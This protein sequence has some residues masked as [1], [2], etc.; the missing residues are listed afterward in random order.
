[1]I[2]HFLVHSSNTLPSTS[3]YLEGPGPCCR[4]RSESYSTPEATAHHGLL[5][6]YPMLRVFLI[7][8]D[9]TVALHR[10]D[11]ALGQQG[12]SKGTQLQGGCEITAVQ[13]SCLCTPIHMRQQLNPTAHSLAESHRTTQHLWH[14]SDW[15]EGDIKQV[16]ESDIV[17]SH[18]WKQQH[19]PR[20]S[21]GFPLSSPSP[22]P[23]QSSYRN[24]VLPEA[25]IKNDSHTHAHTYTYL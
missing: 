9:A 3:A 17:F 19:K 21:P 11:M 13:H 16:S 5:I 6:S 22:S 18:R 10:Q 1:M 4:H 12:N 15:F 14:L 7:Y 24:T 2:A 20:T 23:K 25:V 8:A